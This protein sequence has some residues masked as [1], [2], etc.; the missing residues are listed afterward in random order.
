MIKEIELK[1]NT[2]DGSDSHGSA[3]VIQDQPKLDPPAPSEAQGLERRMEA[4]Y[5]TRDAAEL[6]LLPGPNPSIC[7]I[8]LDISRSG[9]RVAL[10]VTVAKATHLKIKLSSTVI[11]GEVRYCRPVKGGF[12]AGILIQDVIRPP[13]RSEPHLGEDQLSLYA[14]G[15]GLSVA[16]VIEVREH[17]LRCESCRAKWSA[18]EALLNPSKR[19]K[20]R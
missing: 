1:T 5:P 10:P 8:V 7:G 9:L 6:E 15:K 4:R 19:Q 20:R 2:V 12:H 13:E 18:T 17:L 3:I 11:L 16:E 14:V